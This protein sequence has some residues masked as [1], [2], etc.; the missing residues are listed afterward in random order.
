[1][2]DKDTFVVVVWPDVQEIMEEE[3]FDDNSSL[4]NDKPL[5][6]EYDSS[7]YFVRLSWLKNINNNNNEI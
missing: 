2:E 1:M 7:A 5:F 4:I 6:E 3:G